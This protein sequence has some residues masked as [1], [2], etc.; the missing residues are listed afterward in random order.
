MDKKTQLIEHFSLEK[1]PEGGYYKET[2]RSKGEIP[3]NCLPKSIN[4]NRNF[5]TSIYFLLDAN[6]FSSFHRIQQDEIWN[7]HEG[8]AIRIHQIS[9]EGNY[10]S[11]DV[12]NNLEK[13]EVFQHVVPAGYWFGATVVE[14][15]QYSFVGCVVAP[16]FDFEDF[17]LAK[18]KELLEQFPQHE[19][20]I[21]KLTRI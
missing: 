8:S 9:P 2:Y 10:L 18:E 16:G 17:E 6:D 7:F 12:G 15:N 14:K 4:G 3:I 20:I 1:H 21:K 11:I 5:A 19:R 13:N